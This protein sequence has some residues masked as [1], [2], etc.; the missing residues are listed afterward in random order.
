ME[1]PEGVIIVCLIGF[2]TA[3]GMWCLT[4]YHVKKSRELLRE[5][6]CDRCKD[7]GEIWAGW[8]GMEVYEC[9]CK[10]LKKK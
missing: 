5:Y 1:N 4:K 7:T 10:K 8:S 6:D 3:F 2:L 9:E